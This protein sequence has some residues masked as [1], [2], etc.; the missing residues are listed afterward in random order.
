MT[1]EPFLAHFGLLAICLGAGLEGEAVVA[2]GGLLA[3]EHLLP[4]G[5]VMIA[6]AL[7]S[8]AADQLLFFV[9]RHYREHRLVRAITDRPTF[10]TVLAMVERHPRGFIFSFRFLYGLRTLSPIAIGTSS[11]PTRRFVALNALAAIV[12][13]VAIATIGYAF[14]HGIELLFGR[15]RRIEHVVLAVAV[16]AALALAIAWLL[17][18]R[19]L[20]SLSRRT[21]QPQSAATA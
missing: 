20:S 10:A 16:M 18:R 21:E 3:H 15:M 1:I 13:A 12:W 4:L 17:R 5:G 9:G 14:G 8:F 7:G 2:T 11:V 19:T 6:A